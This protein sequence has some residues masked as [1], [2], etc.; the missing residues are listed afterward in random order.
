[1]QGGASDTL[2]QFKI[3][4]AESWDVLRTV[5]FASFSGLQTGCIQH[6]FYNVVFTRAFGPQRTMLVAVRKTLAEC[7]GYI[8]FVY[9]PNYF[10]LKSVFNGGSLSEGLG[11]YVAEIS[12][13]MPKY[14]MIWTPVNLLV[15][16]PLVQ[17]QFRI[18]CVA[19]V[20]F[21]W[22]ALLSYLQ[23]MKAGDG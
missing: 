15:F 3:E 1:V 22:S 16:G 2:A 10:M 20:S 4:R 23:P 8:P 12:G 7:L 17:P 19:A 9:M 13:I 5:K 21:C 11:D 14:W 6:F 18:A